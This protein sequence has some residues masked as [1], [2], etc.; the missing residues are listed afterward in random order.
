MDKLN[1]NHIVRISIYPNLGVA[2]NLMGDI[3][4]FK[5]DFHRGRWDLVFHQVS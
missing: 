3:S 5:A 4:Q 2:L 1:L